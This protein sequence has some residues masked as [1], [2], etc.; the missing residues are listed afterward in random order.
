AGSR[1]NRVARLLPFFAK[2]M[3][4]GSKKEFFAEEDLDTFDGWCRY[5]AIDPK[6]VTPETVAEWRN[7]FEET[8]E[9]ALSTPKV[10]LMKFKPLAPGEFRYGVAIRNG[11]E[12]WLTFWIRRSAKGEF[13]LMMPRGATGWDPHA[14]YHIDGTF[15]QKS[16]GRKFSV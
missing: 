5:Q 3:S 16:H 6:A 9:A 10:G 7:V 14:S 15:H 13:F 12:R 8:R 4:G 1:S 2:T 11:D